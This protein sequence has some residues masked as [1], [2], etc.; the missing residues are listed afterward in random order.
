MTAITPDAFSKA[1]LEAIEETGI[2]PVED[3]E[4][5]LSRNVTPAE[6]LEE[7]LQGSDGDREQGWQDYVSA[8]ESLASL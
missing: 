8:L 4:R 6:L 2:S 5:L 3:L 1:A 7:C